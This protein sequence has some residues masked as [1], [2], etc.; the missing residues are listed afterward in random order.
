LYPR[1]SHFNSSDRPSRR[2][3]PSRRNDCLDRLGYSFVDL[4]LKSLPVESKRQCVK[5]MKLGR[6]GAHEPRGECDG[7]LERSPQLLRDDSDERDVI[8]PCLGDT[9]CRSF[10]TSLDAW[11]LE[12]RQDVVD[13]L[14]IG[15]GCIS[16]NIN[17]V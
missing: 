16:S 17:V 8:Q 13:P 4:V 15:T 12:V 6:L 5:D 9:P 2:T 1:P 10:T 7:S 11:E 14:F 3:P